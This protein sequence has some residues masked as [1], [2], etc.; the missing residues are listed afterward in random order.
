MP[1]WGPHDDD[2][3]YQI[4]KMVEPGHRAWVHD[5]LLWED[6]ASDQEHPVWILFV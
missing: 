1:G 6:A 3:G 4:L 2:F 5:S